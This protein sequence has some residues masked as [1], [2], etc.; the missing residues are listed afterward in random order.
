MSTKLRV[1]IKGQ[2][3]HKNMYLSLSKR[4]IINRQRLNRIRINDVYVE[5]SIFRIFIYR[6]IFCVIPQE[7]LFFLFVVGFRKH[8]ETKNP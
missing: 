3:T 1:N 2:H 5:P 4:K 7:N 8:D 6:G